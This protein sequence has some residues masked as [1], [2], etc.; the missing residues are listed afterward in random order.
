M[1][2]VAPIIP[3]LNDRE[4]P[5]LLKAAQLPTRKDRRWQIELAPLSRMNAWKCTRVR[6]RIGTVIG[7]LP[8]VGPPSGVAMLLPLTFGMDPTS[9]IIMLAA[10]YA[11]TSEQVANWAGT[12]HTALLPEEAPPAVLEPALPGH[13]RPPVKHDCLHSGRGF[14]GNPSRLPIARQRILAMERRDRAGDAPC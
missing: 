9:G 8:G 13:V 1:V 7:A 14:A 11:G 6:R 10:L 3:G 4:V 2:M 5:A 12:R